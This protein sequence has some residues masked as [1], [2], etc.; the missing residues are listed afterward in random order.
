M[1]RLEAYRVAACLP[2]AR[3]V[4]AAVGAGELRRGSVHEGGEVSYNRPG[5]AGGVRFDAL[6]QRRDVP[7]EPAAVEY[8]SDSLDSAY[9]WLGVC[10]CCEG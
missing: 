8:T 6:Q 9:V 7:H 10:A 5:V 4:A 2:A 3:A 1:L